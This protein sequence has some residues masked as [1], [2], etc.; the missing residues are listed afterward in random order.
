MHNNNKFTKKNT[1][2]LNTSV[3]RDIPCERETESETKTEMET[4][5]ETATETEN[6]ADLREGDSEI[7][8]GR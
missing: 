2:N 1:H 6:E 7:E 3:E 5:T 4:E 8:R